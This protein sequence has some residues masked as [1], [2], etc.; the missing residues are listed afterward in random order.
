[1]LERIWKFRPYVLREWRGLLAILLLTALTSGLAALQPWPMKILVDLGIRHQPVPRLMREWL[2]WFRIIPGTAVLIWAAGLGQL[3]IAALSSGLDLVLG[4]LW[5]VVGQGMVNR[6]SVDLFSR[7]QRLSVLFHARQE[8]GDSLSRLS[9]DTWSIYS[10]AASLLI[11]PIQQ[12]MTLGA[13][14]WIAWGLDRQLACLSFVVAPLIAAASLFFGKSLKNRAMG[15][16]VAQSRLTSFI[17]Q[18][19]SAIPLV[20]SVGAQD[21][22]NREFARLAQDAV[23]WAEKGALVNSS[24]GL[25]TG[26]I[27]TAGIAVVVFAGGQRVLAGHLTIGGLLVFAAYTRNLQ[28]AVE[29]LLLTYGSIKPIEASLDRVFEILELRESVVDAPAAV[30][31]SHHGTKPHGYVRVEDV[32]FGYELGTPVLNQVSFEAR[33]G[34]MIALVGPTGAGK[35]T[36][37]S[38]IPRFLDPW[39]GRITFD[40]VDLRDVKLESLRSQ[41]SVMFQEALLFPVSIADN[42]TYG[43]SDAT[44]AEIV[45]AACVA[46]AHEFIKRLP[47]G[48]DTV[49]GS[50][51][52]TLSGGERQRIA[53]ARALVK[54]A[55]VLIM[56]E[57]T[58]ALDAE[59]EA[60]LMGAIEHAR[61]GRTIFLIA[62][63]LSTAQRADRI[64]VLER[65]RIVESGS[66]SALLQ[67]GGAYSRL[68]A[69]QNRTLVAEAV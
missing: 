45:Q 66:P 61:E 2:G 43:K 69:A 30:S 4:W 11:S 26:L 27:T 18:T 49:L 25:V 52:A 29:T 3:A 36:L 23:V 24:Y 48:Y 12:L 20:Q 44:R 13:V 67:S 51:G 41:V 68:H 31:L 60:L 59:S 56:D 19:L 32:T 65:G 63:R 40:G 22:N 58:S 38:L 50:R 5:A 10:I 39:Q 1:M 6:L 16:R 9:T 15:A 7:L 64:A 14:V 35:T 42:I 54:K 37:V 55:P 33:P 62:H 28:K 8:V 34:E 46:N 57:P 21:R 17:Q 47:D 53:I